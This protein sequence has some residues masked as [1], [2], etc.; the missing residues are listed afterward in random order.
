MLSALENKAQFTSWNYNIVKQ[1]SINGRLSTFIRPVSEN[2]HESADDM[3]SYEFKTTPQQ[4]NEFIND[5]ECSERSFYSTCEA[6]TDIDVRS[7]FYFE[8]ET[9]KIKVQSQDGSSAEEE[10]ADWLSDYIKKEEEQDF[11]PN[12]II[13]TT[14]VTD[15]GDERLLV[16][17][18]TEQWPLVD[19]SLIAGYEFN[20]KKLGAVME[21]IWKGDDILPAP[22]E[23]YTPDELNLN[24]DIHTQNGTSLYTSDIPGEDD[25]VIEN[26]IGDHISFLDGSISVQ[27]DKR[28]DFMLGGIIADRFTLLTIL[29]SLAAGLSII[30]FI[31]FRKESEI[32]RIRS[33][34]VSNVSHELR[35][36]VT[37]IRMFSETLVNG[38]V[39]SNE[40]ADRSLKIINQEAQ[41]LGNLVNNVL[42]FSR[43]ERD[44]LQVKF[45]E[46]DLKAETEQTLEAF[47]PIA[48]AGRSEIHR[49]LE[50][51]IICTDPTAYRQMLLNLLDNAVKYGRH[52]QTLRVLLSTEDEYVCLSVEDEG[53]GIPEDLKNKIWEPYWRADS[54]PRA[55]AGSGIGLSLVH[56]Y[57]KILGG[58]IDVVNLPEKGARFELRLPLNHS[59]KKVKS[60]HH[61]N[62]AGST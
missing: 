26:A 36:P 20:I 58:S 13:L 52:N 14:R 50:D 61:L 17:A 11:L 42:D 4:V 18:N 39:R 22:L 47:E 5:L 60:R 38:R 33:D 25:L 31:L 3:D 19:H 37:Q 8:S 56:S 43:S 44:H 32:S 51:V 27:N 16:F 29:F 45:E 28:F 2:I 30:A 23:D 12:Q 1:R 24:V 35:T 6:F 46:V 53:P 21:E 40:E 62:G 59:T 15:S 10:F 55:Q 54:G 49:E 41:R 48:K 34:F 7:I 57:V 9:E